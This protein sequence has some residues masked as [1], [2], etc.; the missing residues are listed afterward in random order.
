MKWEKRASSRLPERAVMV[1]GVTALTWTRHDVSAFTLARRECSA[2]DIGRVVDS[3]SATQVFRAMFAAGAD[4]LHACQG[5]G[6]CVYEWVFT[7]S[8]RLA[9]Y[10]SVF[11]SIGMLLALIGERMAVSAL[12]R[13]RVSKDQCFAK[14]PSARSLHTNKSSYTLGFSAQR[15]RHAVTCFVPAL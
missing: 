3:P 15:S 11:K 9:L 7:E 14:T 12:P 2:S 13:L 8:E 1:T 5:L 10:Y 4:R 6:T